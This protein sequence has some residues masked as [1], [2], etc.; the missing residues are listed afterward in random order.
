MA[1]TLTGR[2]DTRREAELAIEHLVQAHDVK[3]EAI[4]VG[5]AGDRNTA[6]TRVAGSDAA[7]GQ[8]GTRKRE[9]AALN[10]AVEVRVP[11]SVASGDTL[12]DAMREAG[13]RDL[14][15]D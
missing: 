1:Q 8:A 14:S 11:L 4:F 2:F 5:P 15:E 13:A 10:G 9:D 12:R 6:G 3:R 7:D